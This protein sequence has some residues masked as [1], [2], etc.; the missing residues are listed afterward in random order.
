MP[1]WKPLP[2]APVGYGESLRDDSRIQLA[3]V[4]DSDADRVTTLKV[5]NCHPIL[6][7]LDCSVLLVRHKS[8]CFRRDDLEFKVAAG[9]VEHSGR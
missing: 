2:Q 7:Y 4:G 6:D 5:P 8:R 1:T 9:E 3:V